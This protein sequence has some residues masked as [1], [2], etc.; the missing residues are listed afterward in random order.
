MASSRLTRRELQIAGEIDLHPVSFANGDGGE[1][2]QEPAHNLEACLRRRSSATGDD[3]G[4]VACAIREAGSSDPLSQ[5]AD[6][7]HGSRGSKRGPVVLIHL[8]A[9][10]RITDLVE[11][12]KLI[13]ALRAAVWHHKAVKGNGETRLTEGLDGPSLTEH[14][15]TSRDQDVLAAVGVHRVCHQT[16]DRCGSTAVQPIGQDRVDDRSFE[17][18]MERTSRVDSLGSFWGPFLASVRRGSLTATS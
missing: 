18:R 11:P 15:G 16:I 8:V 14:A 2:I 13:E 7:A 1:A 17:K 9:Q 6:Q 10:P 5:A 4:P 3:D 12:E